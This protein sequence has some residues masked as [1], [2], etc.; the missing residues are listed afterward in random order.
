MAKN[1]KIT[2]GFKGCVAGEKYCNPK[3]HGGVCFIEIRK[4]VDS[5]FQRK[6]N[7]TGHGESEISKWESIT[8][9]EYERIKKLAMKK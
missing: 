3:S 8:E 7:S 1:F 2:V 4:K 5:Y 6:I 9:K